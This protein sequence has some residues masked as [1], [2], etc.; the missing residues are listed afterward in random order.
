MSTLSKRNRHPKNFL[1]E[2]REFRY[3]SQEQLADRLE[4]SKSLI[5]RYETGS[6]DWKTVMFLRICAALE[7]RP[8]E[9]FV[10]PMMSIEQ[11]MR[12]DRVAFYNRRRADMATPEPPF[13]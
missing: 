7:I 2:W 11:R 5:S 8:D 12:R 4:T 1:K 13:C 3:L 10:K 6:F 9:L